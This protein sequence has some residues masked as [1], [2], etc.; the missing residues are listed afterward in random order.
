M[1]KIRIAPCLTARIGRDRS[2]A[3]IGVS[4]FD[5]CLDRF[6]CYE[7]WLQRA[8][9][10]FKT[11]IA[12][13]V[14]SVVILTEVLVAYLLIPGRED[15]QAW[16]REQGQAKSHGGENSAL[17][18]EPGGIAGGPSHGEPEVE[19]ELGKFSIVVHKPA[20]SYTMRINFH[21]IGTVKEAER[22]AFDHL[23]A[24]CQHRMR[25]QVIYEVRNS[26]IGD[27]TDPGLALIKRKILAK[28]NDLLG[29]PLLRTVVF[30]DYAFV[31]Q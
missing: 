26:E 6:S 25:D 14:V 28:S 5:L 1:P 21:L 30:S 16:A 11:I 13:S 29:K 10:M 12:A 18:G 15:L 2:V 22:E 9:R 23:L 3:I 4:R 7:V 27:L 31:E 8:A 17:S 24:K 19:V 20:A